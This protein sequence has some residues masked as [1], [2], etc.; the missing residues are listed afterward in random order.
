MNYCI[1]THICRNRRAVL[2]YRDSVSE[3][4]C[5]GALKEKSVQNSSCL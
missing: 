4:I 3:S 2:K 1:T 5:V